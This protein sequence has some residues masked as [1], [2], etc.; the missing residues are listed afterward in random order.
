MVFGGFF[1]FVHAL[2][3]AF[4][5][6]SATTGIS[7]P[8]KLF[9]RSEKED[10]VKMLDLLGRCEEDLWSVTG[11]QSLSVQKIRLTN[12]FTYAEE[13]QELYPYTCEILNPTFLE[14]DSQMTEITVNNSVNT[15]E[16]KDDS[17]L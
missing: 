8:K 12:R 14:E 7:N 4:M 13:S 3:L 9:R 1:C 10:T 6:N 17:E 5:G 16:Q 15:T 11:E 2:I